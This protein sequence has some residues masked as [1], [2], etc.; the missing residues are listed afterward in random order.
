MPFASP[1]PGDVHVNRPLTNI[2]IAYMQDQN[3]FVADSVFPNIP[4]TSQSDQY[5]T[6][7]REDWNRDDVQERA[8]AAETA[9]SDYEIGTEGYFARVKGIHKDIPDQMLANQD[10]PLNLD[11]GATEFVTHK[12]LLH[13]EVSWASRFFN[14]DAWLLNATGVNANPTARGDLN[15]RDNANRSLLKWSDDGSTPIE[16]LRDG[17]TQQQQLTGFRP[18]KLTLS[19]TVFDILVDH[20]AIVGRMDRGQTAGAAMANRDAIA[21]LLELDEVLVMEAIHNEAKKGGVE[22]NQ[23]IA[24]NNALLTYSPR[25]PSLMTPSA[26]YTFSWTGYLGAGDRGI[27][28]KRFYLDSKASTRV[29]AEQAF[30]QKVVAKDM[31]LFFK[32]II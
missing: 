2:S 29:E 20:P 11:Q 23:F 10:S 28:V 31:A 27:R 19:R 15:F 18:N 8:P 17:M 22:N 1:T 25:A 9:G 5:F 4:V 24:G 26:G 14:E 6:Y 13:R 21:A 16:N 7:N 3:S 32:D 30:D 12:Q